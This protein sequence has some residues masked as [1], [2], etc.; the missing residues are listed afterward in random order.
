MRNFQN[1]QKKIKLG[2]NLTFGK[3]KKRYC[4]TDIHDMGL[5]ARSR[6]PHR[7]R[8]SGWGGT[9]LMHG[10]SIKKMSRNAKIR[11]GQC[12]T[13]ITV[14]YLEVALAHQS[15]KYLKIT[16]VRRYARLFFLDHLKET[17]S[18]LKIRFF[19]KWGYG[20]RPA[21]S[22]WGRPA[23]SYSG[24]HYI[25]RWPM[26]QNQIRRCAFSRVHQFHWLNRCQNVM[27][28]SI[29]IVSPFSMKMAFFINF[30]T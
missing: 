16:F 12:N 10:I 20:G 18:S 22:Y 9:L 15:P 14:L 29:K 28:P 2:Q 17:N 19:E 7:A 6:A 27:S 24:W 25:R 26:M 1:F 23:H 8:A 4:K 5:W 21:H 11:I 30:I 3:K 13:S